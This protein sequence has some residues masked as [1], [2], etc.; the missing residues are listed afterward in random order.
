[1]LTRPTL[2]SRHF[3]L[4][5][6]S[7]SCTLPELSG[8]SHTIECTQDTFIHSGIKESSPKFKLPMLKI[9]MLELWIGFLQEILFRWLH[10]APPFPTLTKLCGALRSHA[11]AYSTGQY[12]V[13][14]L[15][16]YYSRSTVRTMF[17]KRHEIFTM[18]A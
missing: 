5:Y 11:V 7:V 8:T 13:Y 3:G 14:V 1:M 10:C 12:K 9:P 4:V 6:T 18:E 17:K 16:S 15:F 2:D